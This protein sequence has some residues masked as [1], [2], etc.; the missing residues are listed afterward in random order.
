MKKKA[1]E[2]NSI[3][4]NSPIRIRFH[5]CSIDVLMAQT[6]GMVRA[7]GEKTV[8]GTSIF[9]N[10]NLHEIFIFLSFSCG[11]LRPRSIVEHIHSTVGPK[12]SSPPRFSTFRRLELIKVNSTFVG[13]LSYYGLVR[14]GERVSVVLA[15]NSHP[16]PCE[17]QFSL[18]AVAFIH[19]FSAW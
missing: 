7:E 11:A 15:L 13:L 4:M 18:S 12:L 2:R 8:S 14:M 5:R 3:G 1:T 19:F 17:R 6:H 9:G 16:V 10:Y